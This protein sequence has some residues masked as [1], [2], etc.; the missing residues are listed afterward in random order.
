M[1]TLRQGAIARRASQA[2][3]ARSA[4][5]ITFNTNVSDFARKGNSPGTYFAWQTANGQKPDFGAGQAGPGIPYAE[6]QKNYQM[7]LAPSKTARQ[8]KIDPKV[9]AIRRRL[10]GG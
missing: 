3:P 10:N 8:A 9:E 5:G 7:Q 6:V 2:M 4:S 1:A